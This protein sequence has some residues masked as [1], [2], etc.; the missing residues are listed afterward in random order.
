MS[1]SGLLYTRNLVP[2]EVKCKFTEGHSYSRVI[3]CAN[4]HTYWL[5]FSIIPGPYALK[6]QLSRSQNNWKTPDLGLQFTNTQDLTRHP[7]L[8]KF[9]LTLP[10]IQQPGKEQH[11]PWQLLNYTA[12]GRV[13]ACPAPL[14]GSRILASTGLSPSFSC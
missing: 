11:L 4:I 7:P 14:A 13:A 12:T 3:L 10:A 2:S 8:Q 1:D 5:P 9:L 6:H